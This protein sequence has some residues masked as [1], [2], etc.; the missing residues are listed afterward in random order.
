MLVIMYGFIFVLKQTLQKTQINSRIRAN[1]FFFLL[2]TTLNS[3]TQYITSQKT[4]QKLYILVPLIAFFLLFEE[5][6]CIFILRSTPQI[7]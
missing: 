4:E 6:S 2:R 3:R 5:G 1:D 7:V